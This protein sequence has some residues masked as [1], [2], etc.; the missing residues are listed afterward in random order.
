MLSERPRILLVSADSIAPGPSGS[1]NRAIRWGL[2]KGLRNAGA[3]VAYVTSAVRER[4]RPDF[5]EAQAALALGADQFVFPQADDPEP[6]VVARTIADFRPDVVLAY[7][8]EPLQLIRSAGYTGRAGIMSVDLEFMPL[9]HRHLYNLRFLGMKQKVKSTLLTPQVALD[10]LQIYRDVRRYYPLADVVINHAAQHARWHS[11]AH[12]KPVLYTPNPLASIDR[13]A[14]RRAPMRPPRFALVG[15]IGGIATLTGLA[16]FARKVY[17]LLEAALTAGQFEI[18]LIGK[19]NLDPAL[20]RIAPRL[21]RRGF[22]DDLSAELATMTAM[23]VPTPIALGFRTRI[24]DAF[25][26]GVAVIAHEANGA[27]FPELRHGVNALVSAT[28]E[29]FAADVLFLASNSIRAEELGLAAFSDFQRE[30]SADRCAEKI[31]NF[32][33]WGGR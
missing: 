18:H 20:G 28:P 27:G 32:L 11:H 19:G 15:G 12:G 21:I 31:L 30:L 14:P 10:F 7:G 2:I 1:G 29:A 33:A 3:E 23:L 16:W 9:L 17:P 13:H 5:R 26:H 8:T 4:H 24:I 6:A 25:R 22:V